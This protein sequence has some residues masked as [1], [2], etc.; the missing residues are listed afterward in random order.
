M[1]TLA[2]GLIEVTLYFEGGLKDKY[3]VR[4][5]D[6]QSFLKTTLELHYDPGI[7]PNSPSG[8]KAAP[9]IK[10]TGQ[11]LRPTSSYWWSTPGLG[12]NDDQ[13]GVVIW[14]WRGVDEVLWERPRT[15]SPITQSTVTSTSP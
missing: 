15:K 7:N 12:K 5:E 13:K 10:I 9:V 2:E 8:S 6:L 3:I 4:E 1:D 11:S 14:H